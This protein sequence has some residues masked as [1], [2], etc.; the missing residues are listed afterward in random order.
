[1]A[2]DGII[3]A[4]NKGQVARELERLEKALREPQTDDRYCQ[5]YAAQQA[6]AW[7]LDPSAAAS[8]YAT[9]QRGLVKPLRGTQEGSADCQAVGRPPESSGICSPIGSPQ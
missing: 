3:F 9:I 8:P 5:L 2:S 1:M 6:L 7:A 4:Q